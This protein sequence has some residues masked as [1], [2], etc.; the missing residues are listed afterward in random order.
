MPADPGILWLVLCIC[1]SENTPIYKISVIPVWGF[2]RLISYLYSVI[3][4]IKTFIADNPKSA[5]FIG[6]AFL[7]ILVLGV[8]DYFLMS[9]ETYDI[10][11]ILVESHGL[12][13]DLIVF[14]IILSVYEE[15]R[16]RKEQLQRCSDEMNHLKYSKVKNAGQKAVVIALKMQ[17]LKAREIDLS[18]FRV[19]EYHIHDLRRMDNW[20]FGNLKRFSITICNISNTS[21]SNIVLNKVTFISCNFENCSFALSKFENVTFLSCTFKNVNFDNVL[22]GKSI[23]FFER[24]K[25]IQGDSRD[26]E[27]LY[28]IKEIDPERDIETENPFFNPADILK[29]NRYIIKP[30]N[31]EAFAKIGEAL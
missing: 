7:I 4:R 13:F 28:E 30:K 1:A 5:L 20:H 22:L 18:V 15:W 24:I 12:F 2:L 31:R 23:D 19:E 16:D 3:D 17:S 11:D 21:F 29:N 6:V 14:G 26:L 9:P 27:E 10:Y 25:N 8:A